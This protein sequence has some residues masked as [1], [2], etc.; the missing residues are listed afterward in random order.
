MKEWYELTNGLDT[1]VRPLDELT[2]ARVARLAR[3]ALPRR[4][5]KR[6]VAAAVAAVL[7]LSACGV[8]VATG[9]FSDWFWNYAQDPRAPEASEDL[10]AG[11]GTVIGQSQTVDGTTITLDGALWDGRCMVLALTV[12]GESAPLDYA[13]SV[14]TE[15]SWLLPPRE[16]MEKSLREQFPDMAEE[17]FRERMDL[18]YE[19]R[20]R[21]NTLV[22]CIDYFHDRRTETYRMQVAQQLARPGETEQRLTLHLEN[23]EFA[24]GKTISGPYEFTFTA[25]PKDMDRVWTG[26]VTIRTPGGYDCRITRVSVSPFQVEAAYE[27]L[28]PVPEDAFL[29]D[30]LRMEALRVGGQEA[31]NSSYQGGLT[32]AGEDGFVHG[33]TF[34]GPFKR[35]ID[36]AAVEA[37]LIGGTWV[38]LDGMT[39]EE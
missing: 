20:L 17:T 23:L 3:A 33:S 18:L 32:E 5:K 14:S 12:D 7:V 1:E 30:E 19:A 25:E 31:K 22:G 16:D 34:R 39:L 8:A 6:W 36:P 24:S 9:R 2:G 35:V 13:A 38:E 11:L 27:M 26:D 29:F 21:F 28:E 15:D 4:R 10:L 37:V